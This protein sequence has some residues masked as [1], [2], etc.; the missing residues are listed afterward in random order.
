MSNET[1]EKLIRNSANRLG[2]DITRYRPGATETGRLA[3]MLR[4]KQVNCVLDVG[5]NAGQFATGLRR[6]GYAE[7]IISFEPLSSA[8]KELCKAAESDEL[9][10]AG[11]RVA[12][13]DR[14]GELLMHIAGNSV[15]SS[16]LEM[17]DSHVDAAPASR[18]VGSE[19]AKMDTLDN[20][21]APYLAD[22]DAV[23]IKI[24][25]QGF[26]SQVLDGGPST[27][28]RATGVQ[29][30]ASLVPLYAGQVLYDELVQRMQAHGF[31]IW[32]IWP[33]LFDPDSGR[34]LP[35]DVSFFR[36]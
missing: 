12:V 17:L 19:S 34:V 20:L 29:L 2:L 9:W 4:H 14:K 5:A 31:S 15:S 1:F 3:T 7:R 23:F 30:E 21:S 28:E 8:H 32:A 33:A 27:L 25:T 18:Y 22:S 11:S 35:A 13:G 6:A 36:D 10:E 24:D 16:A 26:E